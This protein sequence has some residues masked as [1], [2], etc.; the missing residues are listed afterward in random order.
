LFVVIVDVMRKRREKRK[1]MMITSITQVVVEKN[2][3][4]TKLKIL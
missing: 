4:K 2:K 1:V 3:D